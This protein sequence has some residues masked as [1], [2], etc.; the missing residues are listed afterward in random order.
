[1]IPCIQNHFNAFNDRK[2]RFGMGVQKFL[3]QST[4]SI[5]K[6]NFQLPSLINS[7]LTGR[8]LK[9]L[10]ICKDNCLF[11]A[12]RWNFHLMSFFALHINEKGARLLTISQF[13]SSKNAH[14]A[15]AGDSL[16]KTSRVFI[17]SFLINGK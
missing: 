16:D 5:F 7:S 10:G 3:T 17:P 6:I 13:C 15:L 14:T 9:L 2:V 1:M 12:P 8:Q 11:S 4:A